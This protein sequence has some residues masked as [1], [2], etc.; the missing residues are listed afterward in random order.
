MEREREWP[1]PAWRSAGDERTSEGGFE[2]RDH[3]T[4]SPQSGLVTR[5]ERTGNGAFLPN[6]SPCISGT[7]AQLSGRKSR[8]NSNRSP[9]SMGDALTVIAGSGVAQGG[10]PVPHRTEGQSQC[11]LV[12]SD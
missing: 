1:S 9:R 6:A 10:P 11:P 4:P 8:P 12:H 7:H 3:E 2:M 5:C